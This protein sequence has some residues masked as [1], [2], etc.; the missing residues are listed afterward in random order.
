MNRYPVRGLGIFLRNVAN[1]RV[2]NPRIVGCRSLV[3]RV[4]PNVVH[5]RFDCQRKH[6]EAIAG[7][8]ICR[9]VC[10]PIDC[11]NAGVKR[12]VAS[13]RIAKPSIAR[14]PPRASSA[15]RLGVSK[16]N[17]GYEG[18]GNRGAAIT[19]TGLQKS[20]A[21]FLV[22]ASSK[23]PTIPLFSCK[24]TLSLCVCYQ[25]HCVRPSP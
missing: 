14:A 21:G 16:N 13:R 12:R 6:R 23:R 11:G 25:P 4:E 2:P 8:G 3:K 9:T 1:E 22:G 15:R 7:C 5:A 17:Q 24:E 19:P 18:F 20:L 10:R